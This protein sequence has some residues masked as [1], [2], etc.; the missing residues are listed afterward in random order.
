MFYFVLIII[1]DENSYAAQY[2]CRDRDT[3]IF[4]DSLMNNKFK[5]KVFI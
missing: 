2:F 5:R 3:F 1:N 4:Q